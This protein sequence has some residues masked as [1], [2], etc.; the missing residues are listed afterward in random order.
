MYGWLWRH[1]PGP[2]WVRAETVAPY[3]PSNDTT[4]GDE[5]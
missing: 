1:R 3:T 5:P 2:A 4:V